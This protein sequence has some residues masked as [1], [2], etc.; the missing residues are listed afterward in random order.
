MS[1]SLWRA[2]GSSVNKNHLLH[3][4]SVSSGGYRSSSNVQTPSHSVKTAMYAFL[5][6]TNQGLFVTLSKRLLYLIY[7][8]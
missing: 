2:M 5:T 3:H 8:I 6:D 4:Q 7:I 1:A